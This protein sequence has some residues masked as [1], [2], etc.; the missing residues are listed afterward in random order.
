ML[1]TPEIGPFHET[2]ETYNFAYLWGEELIYFEHHMT[3]NWHLL[4]DGI[5]ESVA[6][7]VRIMEVQRRLQH[8]WSSNIKYIL[9]TY[10]F[11]P[12]A[13]AAYPPTIWSGL[14]LDGGARNRPKRV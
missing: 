4:L 6:P 14:F 12:R 7:S 13:I 2:V 5:V 10:R 8:H 1:F 3:D 9:R 11:L